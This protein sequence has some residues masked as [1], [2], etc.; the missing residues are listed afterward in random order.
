MLRDVIKICWGLGCLPR[1]R[2][3]FALRG[4][5]RCRRPQRWKSLRHQRLHPC[6]PVRSVNHSSQSL[7]EYMQGGVAYALG[8]WNPVCGNRHEQVERS[9]DEVCS[10]GIVQ[11]HDWR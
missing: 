7:G 5:L 4:V 3:R 2:H 8:L 1:L 11:K 9:K 10:P 6:V